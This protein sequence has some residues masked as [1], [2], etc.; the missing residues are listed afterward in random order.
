MVFQALCYFE[1]WLGE[2]TLGKAR[3]GSAPAW[4][5]PK[6]PVGNKAFFFQ[7]QGSPS[8]K[9]CTLCVQVRGLGSPPVGSKVKRMEREEASELKAMATSSP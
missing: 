6:V 7:L 2:N 9:L 3:V 8:I 1:A 4:G 5:T